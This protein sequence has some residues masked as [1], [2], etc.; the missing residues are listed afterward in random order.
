MRHVLHRQAHH[1]PTGLVERFSRPTG[2]S[3]AQRTS[4]HL[5]SVPPTFPRIP[6]ETKGPWTSSCTEFS[7]DNKVEFKYLSVAN[8]IPTCVKHVEV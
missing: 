8:N 7:I 4:P 3:L 5:T 2:A 1:K 6:Q